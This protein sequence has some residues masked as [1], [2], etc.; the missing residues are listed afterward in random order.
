MGSA[1]ATIGKSALGLLIRNVRGSLRTTRAPVCC[2]GRP[3]LIE[4]ALDRAGLA[5]LWLWEPITPV[6]FTRAGT[7]FAYLQFVAIYAIGLNRSATGMHLIDSEPD[8]GGSTC[9]LIAESIAVPCSG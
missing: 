9:K 6:F 4:N 2:A 1:S 7:R 5:A 3:G 8:A